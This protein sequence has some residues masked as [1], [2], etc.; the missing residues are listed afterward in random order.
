MTL[1]DSPTD[2]GRTDIDQTT[3]DE[4]QTPMSPSPVSEAAQAPTPLSRRQII[5]ATTEVLQQDG[6]DATTIRRIAGRL[7]C[8]V[9]SIYRYFTDKRELLYAVTQQRFEPIAELAEAGGSFE[10]AVRMYQQRATEA[11]QSYRL[12]FWLASLDP[13]N[14]TGVPTVVSRMLTGWARSLGDAELARE[15][16]TL[17]HGSI[18]LGR[19]GSAI[20]DSLTALATSRTRKPRPT[21]PHTPAYESAQAQDPSGQV[22]HVLTAV[23][24]SQDDMTML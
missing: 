2:A 23:P 4:V 14:P 9:G 13:N 17:L 19:T 24:R 15:C 16:W 7:N 12:M 5:A 11:Q 21:L 20:I 1:Q 18:L 8:A 3:P 6:Y 10:A 22:A